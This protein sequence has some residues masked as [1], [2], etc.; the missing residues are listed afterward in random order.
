MDIK[1]ISALFLCVIMVFFTG[2]TKDISKLSN[3]SEPASSQEVIQK[4]FSVNPLT[5]VENLD[6]DFEKTRP[7]AV[8]INNINVAH[9]VQCGVGSADI[10]YE[11]EVEHGITR[12]MAV[13]QDIS[14][15]NQFGT[16]RSARYAYIDL[17][18]GHN[19]IYCHHGQ[20]PT[21]AA[22]H[23]KD[24]D[25]YVIGENNAGK[26]IT[27]GKATEHTLYGF[28]DKL[29]QFLEKRGNT[30]NKREVSLWQ[31]F[32]KADEKVTLSGGVANE[33]LV[34]F[35]TATKS[36]FTYDAAT[37]EYTR[38][39]NGVML[40]DYSTGIST[41]VKNIFVLM[42]N[43]SNYP[44]NYHR[45]I[46]LSSGTGYYVTNGTYT[47]INWTKGKA[48]EGFKF[49]NTDGSELKVSQGNSW[50]CIA[51]KNTAEPTFS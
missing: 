42:T 25:H 7:V 14:K 18:L 41:R 38:Y 46:D 15:V 17:A 2:C 35:S 27:N 31:N 6:K 40:K 48:S 21:Y 23:L 50:V 4:K 30:E 34:P 39:A 9:S 24:T 32:A 28:G 12:L 44:D 3:F 51:N 1:K 22:P 47:Q 10:V 43:I 45:K 13:Y 29:W 26:R 8:M 36:S 33:V 11:T 16:V 37:E 19:A 5:G 20:D 49:T